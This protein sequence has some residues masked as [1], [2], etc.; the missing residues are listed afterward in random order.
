M[1][2]DPYAGC[3]WTLTDWS[4][5]TLDTCCLMQGGTFLYL[6]SFG[7]NVFFAV[8]FGLF[9]IPNLYLGIKH[10]TWGYMAGMVIGLLLEVLGYAARIMLH[11]NPWDGNGFL[12]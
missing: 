2:I 9:I 1:G 12:L 7:G 3:D 4:Y 11:N 5:C 10:K 6:P 8:F